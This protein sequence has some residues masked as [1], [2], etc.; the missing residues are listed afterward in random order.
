MSPISFSVSV[1]LRIIVVNFSALKPVSVFVMLMV[2]AQMV[3]ARLHPLPSPSTPR[4]P[5]RESGLGCLAERQLP[6]P[7]GSVGAWSLTSAAITTSHILV[8]IEKTLCE[9]SFWDS[10]WASWSSNHG[11]SISEPLEAD[12]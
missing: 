3:A 4:L 1:L 7:P 12:I 5:P 2:A 9:G 8:R 6:W 10:W 11:V